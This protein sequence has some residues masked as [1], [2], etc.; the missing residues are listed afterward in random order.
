MPRPA[1]RTTAALTGGVSG[2]EEL[3]TEVLVLS[4][5]VEVAHHAHAVTRVGLG[6]ERSVERGERSSAITVLQLSRRE[7]DEHALVRAVM[8]RGPLEMLE[9]IG[10][11]AV[12]EQVDA[13][14]V[15]LLRLLRIDLRLAPTALALGDAQVDARAV[16]EGGLAREVVDDRLEA[17]DGFRVILLLEQGMKFRSLRK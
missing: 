17:Q 14:L 6:L 13:D 12:V 2:F 15:G 1:A 4:E 8:L 7:R 3:A 16:T 11:L 10:E 9:S 5:R